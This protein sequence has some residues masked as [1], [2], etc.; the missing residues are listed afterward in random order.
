[1]SYVNS[2]KVEYTPDGRPPER[3]DWRR[4]IIRSGIFIIFILA[5]ALNLYAFKAGNVLNF[6]AKTNGVVEGMIVNTEGQPLAGATITLASAPETQA[7]TL[8]DGGFSLKN[9]PTGSQYLIVASEGIGQGYVITIEANGVT[10]AGILSYEALPA[11][12]N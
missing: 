6:L 7:I 1:M 4:I 9:V 2:P 11:V 8:A 3:K 5:L 10:Q 12:W